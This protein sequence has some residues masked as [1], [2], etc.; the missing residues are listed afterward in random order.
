MAIQSVTAVVGGQAVTLSYD[1]QSGTWVGQYIPTGTSWHEPGHAFDATLTAV[2]STG[3]AVSTD[4]GSFPGL[5][6]VVNETDPPDIT[7]V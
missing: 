2:N 5:R 7:M 3:A 1:S 6:L 4:G